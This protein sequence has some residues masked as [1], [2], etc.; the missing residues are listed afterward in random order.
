LVLLA[1]RAVA[2]VAALFGLGV[3]VTN[4]NFFAS[5]GAVLLAGCALMVAFPSIA[6]WLAGEVE[7]AGRNQKLRCNIATCTVTT[8]ICV[9]F[10]ALAPRQEPHQC[11][12]P[13]DSL[14]RHCSPTSQSGALIMRAR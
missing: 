8:A 5:F 7:A 10:F 4:Q 12:G 11:G 9:A 1:T 6:H 2:L 13:V 14:F 3:F